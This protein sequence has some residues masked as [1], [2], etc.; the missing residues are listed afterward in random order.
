MKIGHKII[1]PYTDCFLI[2]EVAQ[3][4]DGSL[5]MAHAYID[6]V[7]ETGFDAIKFQTHIAV[8]ESTIQE[9]FRVKLSSQDETRFDYWKRMEFT[10]EQW[11]GLAEHA[12]EKGIIFLSSPFSIEAVELLKKLEIQ[13]WKVGSG[14][15]ASDDML[16]EMFKTKKPI[17]FSTGMSTW[18][19]IDLVV[20]NL[21]QQNL[22][23][24]LMQCTSKYPTPLDEVGLN[25]IREFKG[26]Y[27]CFAGLSDHSGTIF[28]AVYSLSQ[29]VNVI[30]VHVTFN[31]K[32]FGPDVASSL[33]LEDLEQIV[34]FRDSF[35]TLIS[36]PVDKNDMANSLVQTRQIFKKSLAPT[37]DLKA[38]Q[39]LSK[40]LITT[41]KPG[42]GIKPNEIDKLIGKTLLRDISSAELFSWDHILQ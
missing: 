42:S 16:S 6:A 39:I 19:E 36:N 11:F 33:T 22:D 34:R 17:L 18:E 10:R 12:K 23:F 29:G 27:D 7:A 13:A 41:K 3:A 4:H 32:M 26:K 21:T 25:V 1:S 30:E 31:K 15:Y 20:E 40:N 14:E 38:G 35:R 24:V 9:P 2:A 5:G 37:K 28:P 8:A